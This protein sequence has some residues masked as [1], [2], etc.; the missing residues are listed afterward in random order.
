MFQILPHLFTI[1]KTQ[2]SCNRPE[3]KK[4]VVYWIPAIIE[5]GTNKRCK[6]PAIPV[7]A[8]APRYRIVLLVFAISDLNPP[9]Y[10]L[11]VLTKVMVSYP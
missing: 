1:G 11:D 10:D 8:A 9:N 4:N 6:I 2:K 7:H 5:L 3:I